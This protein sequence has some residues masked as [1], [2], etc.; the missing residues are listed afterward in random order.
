MVKKEVVIKDFKA[1]QEFNRICSH[2]DYDLDLNQGRYTVDAKSLM[3]IFSLD[4][5]KE[6]VLIAD[7]EN[8]AEVEEKFA[9][10]LK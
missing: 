8:E 2:M 3:G 9:A 5:E 7:T 6:L 1:V 4:L 10:F